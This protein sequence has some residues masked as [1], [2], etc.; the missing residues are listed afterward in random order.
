MFLTDKE[1][2]DLTGYKRGAEQCAWLT[3]NGWIFVKDAH[4][5]PRVAV[6]YFRHMMV[7]KEQPKP[8]LQLKFA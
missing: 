6:E 3:A 4:G 5:K 1:L 8:R 2:V 7:K